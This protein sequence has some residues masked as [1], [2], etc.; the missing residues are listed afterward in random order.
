MWFGI[1]TDA[2][3]DVD[4][5]NDSETPLYRAVLG[6]Y[7]DVAKV[8]LAKGADVNKKTCKGSTPLS[9]VDLG[10]VTDSADMEMATFLHQNGG[11]Q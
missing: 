6:R 10:Q 8:L 5:T 1:L 4:V 3:A 11:H 9:L 2:H 7:M